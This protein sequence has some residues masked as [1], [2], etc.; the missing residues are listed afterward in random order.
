MRL[1][2]LFDLLA[3]INHLL[4]AGLVVREMFAHQISAIE[5]YEYWVRPY[6]GT[7]D[8]ETGKIRINPS[9][10]REKAAETL[11]ARWGMRVEPEEVY[12]A[13]FYHEVHHFIHRK[14]LERVKGCP[15]D[16]AEAEREADQYARTKFLEWRKTRK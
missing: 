13:I 12:V 2:E 11:S 15:D 8:A 9:I 6:W 1:K 14:E 4:P 5:L 7:C 16:R 10:D 3:E